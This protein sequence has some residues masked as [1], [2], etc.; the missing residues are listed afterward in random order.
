MAI[1]CG[2][3]PRR[4][5]V[6]E[7]IRASR[8]VLGHARVFVHGQAGRNNWQ[9]PSETGAELQAA[10]SMLE[11]SRGDHAARPTAVEFGH[12]ICECLSVCVY[13]I[14]VRCR[15]HDHSHPRCRHLHH[16][17]QQP[18]P[19]LHYQV[20]GAKVEVLK[21]KRERDCAT[22][23]TERERCQKEKAQQRVKRQKAQRVVE[24]NR[25]AAAEATVAMLT[26]GEGDQ[27]SLTRQGREVAKVF[28]AESEELKT[29]QRELALEKG[30]REAEEKKRMRAERERDKER[31]AK[32]QSQR[33]TEMEKGLKNLARREKRTAVRDLEEGVKRLRRANKR[34]DAEMEARGIAESEVAALAQELG[35]V[36]NDVAE[37]SAELQCA[38]KGMSDAEREEFDSL[39]QESRTVDATHTVSLV[40]ALGKKGER[41]SQDVIEL[42][43]ELM[44]KGLT[45]PQ[46]GCALTCWYPHL[47][48][49]PSC[50]PTSSS[51]SSP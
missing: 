5:V 6:C 27:A 1:W 34:A 43:M 7:V 37:L 15:Q 21:A 24:E 45:A 28:L 51:L 2:L 36:Q 35:D 18:P 17:H 10:A 47:P 26:R 44:E 39:V 32:K 14:S 30:R 13:T 12:Q 48:D 3:R 29:V 23:E 50:T 9:L 40:G 19:L 49:L 46:V 41:W 38:L 42:G 8:V 11:R 31:A 16:N 4:T 25:R 20:N 33:E 22:E